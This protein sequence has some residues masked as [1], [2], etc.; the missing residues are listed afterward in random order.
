MPDL[1]IRNFPPEDLARLDARAAKLGLSRGE[2][3]RRRLSQ[4]AR[5]GLVAVE[6]ADLQ[7]FAT[8]FA[9]LGDDAV[10]SEAWQ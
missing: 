5:T 1:L 4:D 9:D 10:M 7:H 2:Y 6:V 3:I 8:I